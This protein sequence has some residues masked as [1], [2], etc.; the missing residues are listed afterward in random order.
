MQNKTFIDLFCGIGGFR[1]GLEKHGL[2]CIFSSDFDIDSSF[3]YFK[4]FKENSFGDIT[5]INVKDIPKMDIICG[6]FPCQSFSKSGL[7]KGFDDKRGQLIFNIIEIAKYHKPNLLLLENVKHIFYIDNGNVIKTIIRELENINYKVFFKHLNSS[8]FGIPQRRER[9]YFVCIRKDLNINFN[10]P[11]ETYEKIYLSDIINY[12]IN[13][14]DHPKL[15]LNKRYIYLKNSEKSKY[16]LYNYKQSFDNFDKNFQNKLDSIKIGYHSSNSQKQSIHSIKG[17]HPCLVVTAL[18]HL[19]I[20]GKI[21]KLSIDE[22]KKIMC[23]PENFILHSNYSKSI[24]FLGNA[25]IPK[26][27]DKIYEQ[28]IKLN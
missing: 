22:L 13:K 11:K 18:N 7:L 26:M 2:K 14:K 24:Q 28:I 3:S 23:F 10:F 19:L 27:I 9:V 1:L 15:F 4:N 21:R 20:D 25:V 12:K 8:F 6:G 5:K 17:H 16:K